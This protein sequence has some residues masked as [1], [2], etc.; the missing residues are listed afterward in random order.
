MLRYMNYKPYWW[1]AYFVYCS[2]PITIYVCFLWS[3]RNKD[4]E[5]EE[6][7]VSI[8]STSYEKLIIAM[9]PTNLEN[10]EKI[11]F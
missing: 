2:V 7:E 1:A 11:R 5:A 9:Y 4:H 10:F 8:R 3:R 6:V